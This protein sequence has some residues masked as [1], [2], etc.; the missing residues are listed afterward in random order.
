M[1]SVHPVIKQADID[2]KDKKSKVLPGIKIN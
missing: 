1:A 2:K